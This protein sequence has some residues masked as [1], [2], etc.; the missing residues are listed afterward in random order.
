MCDWLLSLEIIFERGL[1]RGRDRK[2]KEGSLVTV[3]WSCGPDQQHLTNKKSLG[4]PYKIHILYSHFSDEKME[5]QEIPSRV[6]LE[7]MRMDWKMDQIG[8]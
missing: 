2:G 4:Q 5:A 6:S 7:V 3:P 8:S 1:V